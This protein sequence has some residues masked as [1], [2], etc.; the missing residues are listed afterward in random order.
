MVVEV[1]GGRE[2][3]GGRRERVVVVAGRVCVLGRG[4]EGR[5]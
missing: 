3:R 2:G 4:G 5:K 1:V